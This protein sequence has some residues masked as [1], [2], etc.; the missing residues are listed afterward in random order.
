MPHTSVIVLTN[1]VAESYGSGADIGALPRLLV[2]SRQETSF[3]RKGRRRDASFQRS[4]DSRLHAF[5]HSGHRRERGTILKCSHNS[6]KGDNS[7]VQTDASLGRVFKRRAPDSSGSSTSTPA[8]VSVNRRNLN[9]NRSLR[10][11]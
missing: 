6:R 5:T 3:C 10:S 4:G 8:G 9:R 2:S 7:Y 11:Y 1:Q